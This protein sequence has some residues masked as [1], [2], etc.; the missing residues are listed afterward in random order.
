M[1]MSNEIDF[2][3]VL[4]E[5]RADPFNYVDLST[6]HTGRIRFKVRPDQAVEGVGGT[7]QHQ[8]G[9]L[10][11]ILTRERNPKP[12]FS[13]IKGVVSFVREDLEGS[14]VEAKEKIMTIRHPL[15]K[16]EIIERILRQVLHSFPA[17]ERA[18]YFFS[19]EIQAKMEKDAKKPIAVK[20]GDEILTMSLMKRDI[21]VFYSGEPGI[22]HSVYFTP[23][24]SV[25][26]GEPLIGIC[27]QEQ[28]PLIQKIINRVKSEW[29]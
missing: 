11:Y 12:F 15:K 2:D 16:R 28:L 22:I 4:K 13:P 6:L 7:W 20:P 26:Q 1:S 10:L 3:A 14:F 24:V 19:L 23:G 17:P 29:E 5:Y 25:N 27:P 18:R 8:P 21:P 9:T